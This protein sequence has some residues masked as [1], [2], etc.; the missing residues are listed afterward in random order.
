MN[1]SVLVSQKLE[2]A[3]TDFINSFLFC[4]LQYRECLEGKNKGNASRKS[5]FGKFRFLAGLW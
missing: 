3:S 1:R 5:K 4:S 2:I